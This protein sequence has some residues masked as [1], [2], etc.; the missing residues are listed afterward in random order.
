MNKV[1]YFA[2]D[3]Y[4]RKVVEMIISKYHFS[5][6]DA[7]KK[8]LTSQTHALLEDVENGMLMYSEIAIFDMW[9]QEWLTGDYCNS[10]YLLG[11]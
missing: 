6:M 4:D 10:S 5:P 8:F 7:L 1:E 9:E 11:E 3:Y 2:L